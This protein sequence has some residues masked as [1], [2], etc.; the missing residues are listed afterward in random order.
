LD[1]WIQNFFEEFFKK[2]GKTI[3]ITIDGNLEVLVAYYRP[4]FEMYSE[5]WKEMPGEDVKES[6]L[7]FAGV[8]KSIA[9]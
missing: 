3:I 7:Y 6:G 9:F 4:Q 8:E 2:A 1:S 5:F